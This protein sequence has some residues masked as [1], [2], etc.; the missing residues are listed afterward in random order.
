[1]SVVFCCF[2][3]LLKAS[4]NA[5]LLASNLAECKEIANKMFIFAKRAAPFKGKDVPVHYNGAYDVAF[6]CM[7]FSLPDTARPQGVFAP[8]I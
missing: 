8:A 1:M 3:M 5:L 4:C 7:H 6:W 2:F